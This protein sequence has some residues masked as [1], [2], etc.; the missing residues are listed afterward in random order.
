MNLTH[1]GKARASVMVRCLVLVKTY[2][3]RPKKLLNRISENKDTN[4]KVLPWL[5]FFPPKRALNSLCS[6]VNN[7]FHNNGYREGINHILIGMRASPRKVL[8]QFKDKLKLL[9]EGSNTE[10]RFLI[11]FRL[12]LSLRVSFFFVLLWFL[13]LLCSSLVL[14]IELK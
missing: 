13:G 5:V 7:V 14:R 6:F 10:N 4:R 8:I 3:N 1:K 11:I 12:M 9:V 2:G